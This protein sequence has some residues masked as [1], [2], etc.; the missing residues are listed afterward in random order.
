MDQIKNNL[1]NFLGNQTQPNFTEEL[2]NVVQGSD[3][4]LRGT[5]N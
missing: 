3:N 5:Q 4:Q 1:N 2:T